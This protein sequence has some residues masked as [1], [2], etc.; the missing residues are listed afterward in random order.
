MDL[1]TYNQLGICMDLKCRLDRRLVGENYI[2]T[3]L[4][5]TNYTTYRGSLK[6]RGIEQWQEDILNVV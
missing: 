1:D 3:N 4:A 5:H 2:V 6:S